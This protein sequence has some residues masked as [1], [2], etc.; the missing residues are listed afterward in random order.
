MD[1]GGKGRPGSWNGG[2]RI[3]VST[4]CTAEDGPEAGG[5]R[6]GKFDSLGGWQ[7]KPT[8]PE[9]S[10]CLSCSDMHQP[11]AHSVACTLLAKYAFLFARVTVSVWLQFR[12]SAGACLSIGHK[13]LRA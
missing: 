11:D 5:P 8:T 10:T 9:C 12:T 3:R 4:P 13:P 7:D 6:Q 2:T 1:R